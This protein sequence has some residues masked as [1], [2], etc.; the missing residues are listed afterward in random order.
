MVAT[1]VLIFKRQTTKLEDKGSKPMAY[2]R[3]Q[4]GDFRLLAK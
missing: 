2:C 1:F 4:F 3:N